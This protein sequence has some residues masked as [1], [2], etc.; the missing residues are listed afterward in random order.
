MEPTPSDCSKPDNTGGLPE[1]AGHPYLLNDTGYPH[2]S[3]ADKNPY[4]HD[5]RADSLS[6]SKRHALFLTF[7]TAVHTCTSFI[8]GAWASSTKLREYSSIEGGNY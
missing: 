2:D 1:P 3:R 5:R 6:P 4:R 8:R 7:L